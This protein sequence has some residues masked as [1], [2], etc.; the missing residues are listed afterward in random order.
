MQK[1]NIW[2]TQNGQNIHN[3]AKFKINFL[4]KNWTMEAPKHCK[5]T[6]DDGRKQTRRQQAE[7]LAVLV[8]L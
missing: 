2:R 6:L 8:N 3:I 7:T 1:K 4:V 5:I